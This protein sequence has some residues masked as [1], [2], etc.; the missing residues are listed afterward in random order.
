MPSLLSLPHRLSLAT[1]VLLPLPHD[2]PPTGQDLAQAIGQ[3]GRTRSTGQE[4]VLIDIWSPLVLPIVNTRGHASH[5]AART[6]D[7]GVEKQLG[8]WLALFDSQAAWD[9]RMVTPG[10]VG[11]AGMMAE[12]FIS[13]RGYTKA[14]S[15]RRQERRW[16]ESYDRAIANMQFVF[17]QEGIH[18]EEQVMN[19]VPFVAD[20]NDLQLQML[21]MKSQ[22][23]VGPVAFALLVLCGNERALDHLLPALMYGFISFPLP[24]IVPPAYRESLCNGLLAILNRDV[25]LQLQG[26]TSKDVNAYLAEAFG[27]HVNFNYGDFPASF[28]RVE[29]R[30]GFWYLHTKVVGESLYDPP[31]LEDLHAGIPPVDEAIQH[32]RIASNLFQYATSG[33]F[34]LSAL[35]LR[36]EYVGF[37]RATTGLY[38]KRLSSPDFTI[39]EP[40]TLN[41]T[42]DLPALPLDDAWDLWLF[43]TE[44]NLQVPG[45][46]SHGSWWAV[47]TQGNLSRTARWSTHR[48]YLF[49]EGWNKSWIRGSITPDPFVVQPDLFR[50]AHAGAAPLVRMRITCTTAILPN[51]IVL[52]GVR[53]SG[54]DGIGFSLFP[55]NTDVDLFFPLAEGLRWEMVLGELDRL[56]LATLFYASGTFQLE[57]AVGAL[58]NVATWRLLYTRS[59]SPPG[60]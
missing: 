13:K 3:Y 52:L 31:Q 60:P 38:F 36:L 14:I 57:D 12:T 23:A 10:L 49:A 21:G 2:G 44:V 40:I 4:Q 43:T 30:E 59:S 1:R 41:E 5:W 22:Q 15:R 56:P 26:D 54:T 42:I 9:D 6:A 8:N 47:D 7:V 11:S 17:R 33:T 45:N 50:F 29:R 19:A 51:V 32:V 48:N 39:E 28:M 35:R 53:L 46:F 27:G 55:L 37:N 16:K 34:P 25:Y 24:P 58:S 20:A 18:Y